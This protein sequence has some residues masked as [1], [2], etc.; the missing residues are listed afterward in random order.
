MHESMDVYVDQTAIRNLVP[1]SLE[2]PS[3]PSSVAWSSARPRTGI[4]RVLEKSL[5][6]FVL[7][8]GER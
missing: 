7:S 8:V 5:T 1:F 2:W 3:L 4:G 6:L